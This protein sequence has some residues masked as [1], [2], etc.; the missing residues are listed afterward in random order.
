MIINQVRNRWGIAIA[1]V[2]MQIC[3]GAAYGWSVFKNPL[4]RAEH[5]TETSVQLNFTLTIV[6]FGLG[7]I[8]G[9]FWQDRQGPRRV[10]TFASILYGLGYVLAGVASAQH[11]LYGLY[12]GYGMLAGIGMGIGYICPVTMLAKWFPDKRGLMTGIAVCGYGFGAFLMSPIAAWEILHY[13]VPRTFETLGVAYLILT[14]AAAQF[15]ANPPA[16]WVPPGWVPRTSVAKAATRTDFT[17]PEAFGTWQLYLLFLL[18]FL[19]NSSGLMIIG[20]AS[21]MAQEMVGMPV[22]RA[23]GAVGFISLFNGLGRIFWAWISDHIGRAHVYFLLYLIQFLTYFALLRIH[24][25]IF[26]GIAY[27]FVGLCYGGGLGTMPSFTADY[28]GSKS[29]GAI[30][31]AV[32]FVGNLSAIPSP[33]LIAKIHQSAGRYEPALRLAM[34][35][36]LCS[37]ILPLL[38]RKPTK[39]S[40]SATEVKL[41]PVS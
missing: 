12:L 11:S 41:E 14:F 16:D 6:C 10:A 38:S 29:M 3:L 37:L 27:A 15:F 23:A 39:R 31:G 8:I 34:T 4:M 36:M 28:F 7:T 32:L 25:W 2:C 22:V 20:Q 9:G 26:F 40:L 13:S 1:A 18:L 24:S 17:L 21:P 19:N 33:L 5:W 35:V 30:Y